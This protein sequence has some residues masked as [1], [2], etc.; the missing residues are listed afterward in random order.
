MRN[1]D[2]DGKENDSLVAVSS[3]IM[4]GVAYLITNGSD[5]TIYVPLRSFP[6]SHRR[7]GQQDSSPERW[8]LFWTFIDKWIPLPS[9][10]LQ[11]KSLKSSFQL[12]ASSKLY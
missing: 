12:P 4:Q 5:A 6:A 10:S 2:G 9:Q 11:I 3:H 7:A 8:M 1:G